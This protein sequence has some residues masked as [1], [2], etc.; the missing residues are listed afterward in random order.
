VKSE[1]FTKD[2]W[3]PAR[4]IHWEIVKEQWEKAWDPA[5]PV[6]LEKSPPHLVRAGQ[7]ESHFPESYF[8]VMMRNPYAFCEGMMR[9]WGRR[10]SDF[11]LSGYFNIAKFWAI[12]ARYQIQNQQ[13]LKKTLVLTYEELTGRP[14]DSCRRLLDFLP[15]LE[16]LDPAARFSVFEKSRPIADLN[17]I[18]TARLSDKAIFEINEVLKLYPQFLTAFHYRFLEPAVYPRFKALSRVAMRVRALSPWPEAVK[19]HSWRTL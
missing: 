11:S 19:W 6:L 8:I 16:W 14:E 10:R 13:G 2:R 18:Q 7:L 1:L 9:R 5:R 3:N 12:C 4:P 17:E 15:E